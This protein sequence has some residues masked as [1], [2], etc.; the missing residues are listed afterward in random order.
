MDVVQQRNLEAI[1]IQWSKG[2]KAAAGIGISLGVLVVAFAALAAYMHF[3]G[4]GFDKAGWTTL[5]KD[6]K[7]FFDGSAQVSNLHIVIAA[8]GTVAAVV[9]FCVYRKYAH[10]P[11]AKKVNHQRLRFRNWLVQRAETKLAAVPRPDQEDAYDENGVKRAKCELTLVKRQASRNSL[12]EYMRAH[13]Q[14]ND[15]FDTETVVSDD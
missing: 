15:M 10:D 11:L 2:G 14:L 3:S 1:D 13:D 5:G 12:K 7:G 9:S 4:M 6:I 8:G